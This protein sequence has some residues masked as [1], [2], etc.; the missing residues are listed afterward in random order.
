MFV[1]SENQRADYP[2][3][4]RMLE[5][6]LSKEQRSLSIKIKSSSNCCRQKTKVAK[7]NNQIKNS[8]LDFL[9][10]I[11]NELVNK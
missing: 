2:R 10:K 11:S 3:I 6:K 8:R 4:F 5:S 7:I 9:H 1:S